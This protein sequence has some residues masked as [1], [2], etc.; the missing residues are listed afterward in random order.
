M[1]PYVQHSLMDS[2]QKQP[3]VKPTPG[4][5]RRLAALIQAKK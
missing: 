4:T 5:V 1:M 3:L 2:I